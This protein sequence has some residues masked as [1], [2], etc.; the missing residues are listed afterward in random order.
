[1]S[2]TCA[3]ALPETLTIQSLNEQPVANP[4]GLRVP[5]EEFSKRET[6][7]LDAS[8]TDQTSALEFG[9]A[10]LSLRAA[11]Y[12]HG[13]FTKWITAHAIDRNRA[14]YCMRVA[15]GKGA[16]DR[17]K[18]KLTRQSVVKKHVDDLFKLA[19]KGTPEMNEVCRKMLTVVQ[20]VVLNVGT[21]PGWTM[22]DLK[23]PAVVAAAL[24]FKKSFAEL[25]DVLYVGSDVDDRG[26]IVAHAP[27]KP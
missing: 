23:H 6:A 26:E 21:L 15:N 9:R 10:L 11:F 13:D 18:N 20:S 8:A 16:T 24:A 17:A 25:L 4:T 2:T 22:N 27:L 1:V 7:A 3:V 5:A 14:S 19:S 12:V